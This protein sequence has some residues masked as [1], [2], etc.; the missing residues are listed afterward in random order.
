M[1]VLQRNE[2]VLVLQLLWIDNCVCVGP[3]VEVKKARVDILA[4]FECDDVGELKE[5]LG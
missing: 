5:Y 2:N 1:P 4:R 3:D